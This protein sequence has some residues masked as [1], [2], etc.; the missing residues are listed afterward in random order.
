MLR[1]NYPELWALMLKWD[2][3][4]PV[5]FHADNH[6][7]HDFDKR[8]AMEDRGLIPTDRKFRWKMLDKKADYEQKS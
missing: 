7:V 8:F 6:T 4:S 3:D 1:K 5:S 2:K